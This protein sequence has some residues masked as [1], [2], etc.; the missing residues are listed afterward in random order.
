ME[1]LLVVVNVLPH[2]RA[3]FVVSTCGMQ[4]PGA[5]GFLWNA[6]LMFVSVS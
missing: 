6:F 3:A 2:L 4:P 1:T 5:V